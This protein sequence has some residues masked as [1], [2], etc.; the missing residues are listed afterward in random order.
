[1]GTRLPQGYYYDIFL[2]YIYIYIHTNIYIYIYI[3][4]HTYIHVYD[5]F[6]RRTPSLST[7]AWYPLSGC[8]AGCGG[9]VRGMRLLGAGGRGGGA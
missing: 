3:H 2:M 7:H 9:V 1:M 8:G 5:P 4:A 6:G